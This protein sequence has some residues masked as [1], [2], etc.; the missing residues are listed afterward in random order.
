[1]DRILVALD[2]SARARGVLEAAVDLALRVR[3][4]LHL[5]R[6]VPL[7]P[8]LPGALW[9]VPPAD[10]TA[11]TLAAARAALAAIAHE[12]PPGLVDGTTAVVGTPWD[13]IC[14]A[15]RELDVDCIVVGS[16]GYGLVERLLGTTAGKV[17]NHA[18]RTVLVVREP[19][20]AARKPEP[21][22]AA[23]GTR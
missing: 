10:A 3:G 12:L 11:T 13:A 19:D 23:G 6:A 8:E 22:L 2:C 21:S 15:A 18:D 1:M 17:V 16:H 5:L 4:K 9:A 7:P 14:A 20:R